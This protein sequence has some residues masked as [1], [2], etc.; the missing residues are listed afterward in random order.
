MTTTKCPAK[1]L[2]EEFVMVCGI[3]TLHLNKEWMSRFKSNAKFTLEN[4]PDYFH[5]TQ[6]LCEGAAILQKIDNTHELL[7]LKKDLIQELLLQSEIILKTNCAQCPY[8]SY[9]KETND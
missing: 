5:R 1:E 9:N 3:D 8:F 6:N 4:Y 2:L 7:H